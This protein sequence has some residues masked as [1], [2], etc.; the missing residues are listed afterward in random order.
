VSIFAAASLQN[1]LGTLSEHVKATTGHQ[2]IIVAAGSSALARQIQQGAPADIFI[3][4]N[5]AWM[6]LLER[7]GHILPQSRVDLLSNRLAIIA[8]RQDTGPGIDPGDPQT[9]GPWLGAQ[10]RFAMA[11]VQSVPAGIYG[12]Q[13][14]KH[15]GLWDTLAPRIA[16][17][18]NVRAALALV[19]TGAAPL[20]LVYATDAMAEPRVQILAVIPETAHEPILYP[21]ALVSDRDAAKAVLAYLQSGAARDL[22]ESH[23][24]SQPESA[25]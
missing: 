20:G 8:P 25:P 19:A 14:L 23:G 3:S 24:F 2:L 13:A 7:E 12:A 9:L 1:V 11:L 18:D 22:Y 16:Q 17:S 10:G 6:D 5:A 4:A 21:A 15:L